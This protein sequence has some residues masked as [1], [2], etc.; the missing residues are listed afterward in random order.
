MATEGRRPPISSGSMDVC[1][2]SASMSHGPVK[3]LSV[4]PPDLVIFQ[5]AGKG[6]GLIEDDLS[7]DNLKNRD[8]LCV[9]ELAVADFSKNS[10]EKNYVSSGKQIAFKNAAKNQND[11]N[12]IEV[13]AMDES[14]IECL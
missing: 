14:R 2:S 13:Q 10:T 4:S 12:G 7:T 3:S 6:K 1:R 9:M 11:A 8:L 5:V